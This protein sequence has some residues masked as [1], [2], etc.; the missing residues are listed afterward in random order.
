MLPRGGKEGV[1]VQGQGRVLS[2]WGHVQ[3]GESKEEEV[4]GEGMPNR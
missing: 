4:V 3:S 1:C 2:K